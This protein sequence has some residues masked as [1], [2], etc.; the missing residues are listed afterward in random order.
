MAS[1]WRFTSSPRAS[2]SPRPIR[3]ISSASE[4]SCLIVPSTHTYNA[5]A[6]RRFPVPI[7]GRLRALHLVRDRDSE[8]ARDRLQPALEDQGGSEAGGAELGVGLLEDRVL[9][10]DGVE[11]LRQVQGVAGEER[12]LEGRARLLGDLAGLRRRQDRSQGVAPHRP[13]GRAGGPPAGPQ[14]AEVR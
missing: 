5:G 10:V 1:L 9:V 4:A 2:G 8:Q 3:A 6:S 14:T 12:R 11:L 7:E 13:A